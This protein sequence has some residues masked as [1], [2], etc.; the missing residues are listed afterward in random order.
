MDLPKGLHSVGP[1]AGDDTLL[2]AIASALHMSSAP[3][4]GQTAAAAEKNPSIWM[5]TSQPPCKAFSVS[6]THIREQE[7]KV[8]Q[9]RRSLEEALTADGLARAAE[10]SRQLL[11]GKKH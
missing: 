4:T 9:A 8:T 1:D 11:K 5:N 10:S 3:I 2:S 7:L 6:D